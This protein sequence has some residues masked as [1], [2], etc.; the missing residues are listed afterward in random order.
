MYMPSVAEDLEERD[1]LAFQFVNHA[2]VSEVP[3]ED[4]YA[5]YFSMRA[6]NVVD[7]VLPGI[8]SYL[9]RVLASRQARI[10]DIGCGTGRLL[11]ALKLGGF[12]DLHGVDISDQAVEICRNKGLPVQHIGS[13]QEIRPTAV[14][15]RFDLVIL[16]HVLE[17]IPKEGAIPT[18]RHIRQEVLSKDG[19]LVVIVP[20]AQSRTG[21]YWAYEDFTHCTLFT[22]GSLRYVLHSAGF[23]RVEFLDP[24]CIADTRPVLRPLKLFLL[25]LYET[26]MRFWNKITS[27]SFHASSPCIYSFEIKALAN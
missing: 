23:G 19:N 1:N 21:C 4:L 8:P 6:V 26:R 5:D 3:V 16:S 18:L 20:N 17:H 2:I 10:L 22:A 27:S 11:S 12:Q 13:I 9:L 25:F 15:D 7:P 14:G 24:K